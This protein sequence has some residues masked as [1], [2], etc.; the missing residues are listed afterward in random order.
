MKRVILFLFLVFL[1]KADVLRFEIP[2]PE[3]EILGRELI[4]RESSFINIT[5]APELPCR[6]ITFALPPGAILKDVK[7]YGVREKTGIA[8]IEPV[9]PFLPLMNDKKIIK[10]SLGIY[11]H[12]RN[13]Y[14]SSDKIYPE[15][16][17]KLISK[18]GIRKYTT[19]DIALYHFAWNPLSKEIFVSPSITVEVYYTMPEPESE[20][21]K[22][23]ERLKN[24]I[25]FDEI[26]EKIIYNW[27][28][29]KIWYKPCSPRRVDG[30]LIILPESLLTSVSSLVSY[31]SNQGY[32]VQV[33]TKEYIISST[34]GIDIPQKIRN[35]LR[36][37][38]SNITYVLFVGFY[39]DL[40]MR[41]LVPF[42]D[43]PD[44]PWDDPDISPIPSDMYYADLSEPDS[45]SWN[46]DG[47]GYFG[48]VYDQYGYPNGDDAPDY[49]PDVRIGR[50]P[51]S[52]GYVIEDVINKVISFD[53]NSDYNY[54]TSSLL[55]GGMIYFENENYSGRP[56]MDGADMMELMMDEGIFERQKSVYLYEKS[57]LRP[58]PYPCTDSLTRNNMIYY[59]QSKGIMLEYNHGSPDAYW[60]K[61][62]AWDDGDSVPEY[63]GEV[64][65]P[66]CLETNDVIYLDNTYP[67]TCFLRS[68]LTGKPEEYGLGAYLLYRGAS[69]VFCATRILWASPLQDE[70]LGYHFYKSLLKDS[71]L[72]SGITGNAFD[73]AKEKFMQMNNFWLNLYLINQYGDPATRHF[74]RFTGIDEE[75]YTKKP[76]LITFKNLKIILPSNQKIK[77]ELYDECGRFLKQ[78]VTGYADRRDNE[79]NLSL[80]AGIYFIRIKGKRSF[81]YHKVVILR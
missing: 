68:C 41:S 7:F 48:E 42:N 2:A 24:D 80:N 15:N 39:Y 12:N 45:L 5:G 56:R 63:N 65:F 27:E 3:Y 18:G 46:L 52:T 43:D 20:R 81:F 4:V 57:G 9:K 10:K 35:Y 62:W 1:L 33:V 25:T 36:E 32:N 54:K 23:W 78:I 37:N 47:D 38:I 66:L 26:A 67:A 28:Q 19:V 70:G 14:Y 49:H 11:E 30:Y 40:P 71:L 50:F 72:S 13:I 79:F 76:F 75:N 31:R 8:D 60:R 51:Y 22:F 69:C 59:W 6:I 73:I 53:S 58:S 74:G 61:I 17:G 16:F 29:A 21:A 34:P 77:V 55:A 44:S 64:Q